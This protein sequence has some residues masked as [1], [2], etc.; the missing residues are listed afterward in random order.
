MQNQ[1][2][3]YTLKYIFT[4]AALQKT[5]TTKLTAYP[6][7]LDQI[8]LF[9]QT[10]VIGFCGYLWESTVTFPQKEEKANWKRSIFIS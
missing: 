2:R 7:Y 4:I 9:G 5:H 6:Q 10:R 3:G 8:L 1:V